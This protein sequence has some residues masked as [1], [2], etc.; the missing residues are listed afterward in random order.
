MLAV[1]SWM[2][3]DAPWMSETEAV[4]PRVAVYWSVF[5]KVSTVEVHY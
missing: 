4:S 1:V 3:G 2:G 5:L